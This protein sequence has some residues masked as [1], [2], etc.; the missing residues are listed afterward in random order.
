MSSTDLTF[1]FLI[2]SIV[3]RAVPPLGQ[4]VLYTSTEDSLIRTI[5]RDMVFFL[6]SSGYA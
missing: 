6:V 2:S 5:T 4:G 3:F 1:D